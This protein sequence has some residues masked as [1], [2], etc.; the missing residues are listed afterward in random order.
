MRSTTTYGTLDKAPPSNGKQSL[1]LQC[2]YR[3]EKTRNSERTVHSYSNTNVAGFWAPSSLEA[4]G[5]CLLSG[6]CRN[7]ATAGTNI[8]ASGK[9][10]PHMPLRLRLDIA[11][12]NCNKYV[13]SKSHCGPLLRVP[14]D[15]V[16]CR[17]MFVGCRLRKCG[18]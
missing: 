7:F 14:S 15:A 3:A 6:C 2:P 17:S 8:H 10:I 12:L 11:S 4:L 16:R 5:C 9:Q 13:S 1:R 18:G